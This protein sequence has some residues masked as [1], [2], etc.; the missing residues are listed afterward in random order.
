M[1]KPSSSKV[2]YGGDQ[3]FW[4][5]QLS[6]KGPGVQV[7]GQELGLRVLSDIGWGSTYPMLLTKV[8]PVQ[9]ILI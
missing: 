3:G 9:S 6:S 8:N 1:S 4:S 2:S 7:M 5:F